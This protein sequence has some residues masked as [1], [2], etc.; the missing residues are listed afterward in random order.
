MISR[1]SFSVDNKNSILTKNTYIMAD[2]YLIQGNM[3]VGPVDESQLTALGITPETLVW[4]EGMAEWLPASQVPELRYLFGAATPPPMPDS[5]AYGTPPNYSCQ[6]PYIPSAKDKTTAGILAILLG[7]LGIHYFYLG[8]IGAGIVTIL[9]SLVTCGIWQIVM[10]AQGII[11][12]T[13]SDQQFRMK[14]V[15]NESFMPLF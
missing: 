6:Q 15:D 10:L 2:W 14:Y 1:L 12:L 8:K 9:L 13:L 3:Q 4:R 7:G 11:M 5:H